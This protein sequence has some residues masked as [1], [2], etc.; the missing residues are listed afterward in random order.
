MTTPMDLVAKYMQEAN[1][2]YA[3]SFDL[4]MNSMNAMY[5][6]QEEMMSLYQT[7]MNKVQEINQENQKIAES[8]IKQAKDSQI[9]L[10]TLMAETFDSAMT[11]VPVP[12]MDYFKEI[13]A[14]IAEMMQFNK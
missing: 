14:K 5:Q 13:N 11:D 1:N 7:S 2:V 4:Y 6:N 10:K 9:Q 3:K 12:S 8:L